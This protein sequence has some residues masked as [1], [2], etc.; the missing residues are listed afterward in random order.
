MSTEPVGSPAPA[1]RPRQT[2]RPR[3]DTS[4]GRGFNRNASSKSATASSYE[5]LNP[6]SRD[7]ER[8]RIGGVLNDGAVEVRNGAVGVPSRQKIPRGSVRARSR[9]ATDGFVVVAIARETHRARE[10]HFHGIDGIGRE[11][12]QPIAWSSPRPQIEISAAPVR[13]PR[14][15]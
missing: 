10:T 13:Y 15:T 7:S 1:V 2:A 14:F 3:I 12:F 5:L 8:V 11:R 6:W 9:I 4:G